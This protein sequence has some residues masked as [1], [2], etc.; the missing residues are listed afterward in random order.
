MQSGGELSRFGIEISN[1]G[2]R[3][4]L[5]AY[6][7][8]SPPPAIVQIHGRFDDPFS[9]DRD[10]ADAYSVLYCAQSSTAAFV[11]AT[12]GLRPRLGAIES[13]LSQTL[14]SIEEQESTAALHRTA[15][16]VT[17]DWQHANHLTSA[18]VV[19]S[20]LLL[21]L[22]NPEAVQTLRMHL[23]PSLIAMR[24]DD[25]DF[26]ELVGSNRQ[27]TQAISR[28]VW[29]MKG[30]E[31]EPLFSGIRYRSRFDPECICFALYEDRYSIDGDI[32]TQPITLETPGFA[33]AAA[34]L[35]L[36]IA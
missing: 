27:L 13:L 20:A 32:D 6:P 15:G 28:W 19:T 25:L 34:T 4:S 36:S 22:A 5:K 16:E 29:S 35:R 24:L 10:D 21:D 2:W 12:S 8:F 17:R 31:A 3:V 1:P 18:N 11:E 30:E 26:G 9:A 14:I 23:A 7:P 33:E